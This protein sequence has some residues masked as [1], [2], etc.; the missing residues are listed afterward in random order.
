MIQL[1]NASI[2]LERREVFVDGQPL[3]LGGRAFDVLARLLEA[4]GRLVT[5]DELLEQVWPNLVV[6]E[7]NLQVHICNLRRILGLGP[8]VIETVPRLGYRLNLAPPA[9][10]EPVATEAQ[11]VAPLVYIVDDDPAVCAAIMRLLRAEGLESVSYA[12]A[13]TFLSH[14]TLG[15]PG[16]LLLDMNLRQGSGFDLQETLA[17]RGVALPIIFMT[18]HGTIALSVKAMKA[19]AEEFLT[20]PFDDELLLN[21]VRN[22]I[23]Q[24]Q[25]SHAR[26]QHQ[27]QVRQRLAAL[28]PRERQVLELL[29]QGRQSKQVAALLGTREVT[30]KV[31]KKHIMAK[32]HARTLVELVNLC[33]MGGMV[34]TWPS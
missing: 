10:P 13:A 29:V 16:C 33:T 7:N 31:H 5:K 22:A 30:V 19:G 14:L 32:M 4:P 18:G 24:A 11:A 6:E 12:D 2:F 9:R 25:H 34:Q 15:R 27:A 28:T 17:L 8:K 26:Q 20:K 23:S 21:A 3:R 1:G